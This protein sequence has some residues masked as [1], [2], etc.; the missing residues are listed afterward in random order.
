MQKND[1]CHARS[2][3]L[4]LRI[5]KKRDGCKRPSTCGHCGVQLSNII[6]TISVCVTVEKAPANL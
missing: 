3:T 1:L 2:P 4:A 6:Q 5:Y